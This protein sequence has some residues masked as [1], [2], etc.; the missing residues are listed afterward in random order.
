MAIGGGVE[1][2]LCTLLWRSP[3]NV[4]GSRSC[5]DVV[6]RVQSAICA[7]L[8]RERASL[9]GKQTMSFYSRAISKVHEIEESIFHSKMLTLHIGTISTLNVCL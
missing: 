9:R 8:P 7:M 3:F 1:L 4:D 5:T 6:T 2:Q